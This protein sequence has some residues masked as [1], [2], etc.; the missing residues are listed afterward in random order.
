MEFNNVGGGYGSDQAIEKI[1]LSYENSGL[2]TKET[3][4]ILSNLEYS[5]NVLDRIKEEQEAFNEFKRNRRL[6]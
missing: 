4:R 5:K 2:D 6:R 1:A 3:E